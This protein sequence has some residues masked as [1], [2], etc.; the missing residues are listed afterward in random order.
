MEEKDANDGN[1]TQPVNIGAVTAHLASIR[2]K[3]TK[4]EMRSPN[5]WKK[6][7]EDERQKK[8]KKKEKKKKK[9][10]KKKKTHTHTHTHNTHSILTL[11]EGYRIQ[12]TDEAGL[13]GMSSSYL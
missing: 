10:K 13:M 9:K 8:K 2:L 7:R 6:T 3:N 1:S 11:E 12:W 5:E 4:V